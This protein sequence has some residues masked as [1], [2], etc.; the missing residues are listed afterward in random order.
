MRIE[1]VKTAVTNG[2]RSAEPIQRKRTNSNHRRSA[3]IV[4][5]MPFVRIRAIPSLP[6]NSSPAVRFL[7]VKGQRERPNK[8]E[9]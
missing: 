7:F 2:V 1:R 5:R 6:M 9:F 8:P 4:I 3:S